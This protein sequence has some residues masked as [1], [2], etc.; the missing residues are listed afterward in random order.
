[1]GRAIG[2]G[3]FHTENEAWGRDAEA[4]SQRR[5]FSRD[6]VA[7]GRSKEEEER[8]APGGGECVNRTA[9]HSTAQHK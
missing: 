6:G 1:M 7:E 5:R 4:L 3:R 9:P 8:R 2:G